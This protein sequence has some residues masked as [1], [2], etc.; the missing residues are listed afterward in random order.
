MIYS[1]EEKSQR[2]SNLIKTPRVYNFDLDYHNG[3]N[4]AK[5]LVDLCEKYVKETDIVVEVGSFQGVSSQVIALYCKELNCIDPW[6]WSSCK[7]AEKMFDSILKDYPN[8]NKIKLF[9][10]EA[11][12][13]FKDQSLDIVYIDGDH[14]HAAVMEDIKH[15]LPKVKEGGYIAGHDNYIEEVEKAIIDNFGKNY[16]TF[17]DTSWIIQK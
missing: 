15:W 5:G 16:E 7:I 14:S 6:A 13:M 9:S 10:T 17:S 4:C 3:V 2:I 11:S 12:K 1:R 8:I